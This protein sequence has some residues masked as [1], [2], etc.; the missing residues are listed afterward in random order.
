MS[1]NNNIGLSNDLDFDLEVHRE[2][3]EALSKAGTAGD[4]IA[5]IIRA[6]NVA[7]VE[8]PESRLSVGVCTDNAVP[9]P[10][11]GTSVR[12]VYSASDLKDADSVRSEVEKYFLRHF[13]GRTTA[14][15]LDSIPGTGKPCVYVVYRKGL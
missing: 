4:S 5:A 11:D 14:N 3:I 9:S 12:I 1:T 6:R 13:P 15:D 8:L 2:A 10:S 7:M